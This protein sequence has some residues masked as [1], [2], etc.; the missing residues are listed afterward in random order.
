MKQ[1]LWVRE[2]VCLV[3]LEF[4]TYALIKNKTRLKEFKSGFILKVV[5][6]K[7]VLPCVTS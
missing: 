6:G 3:I 4:E 5:N 1:N 2:K 7:V